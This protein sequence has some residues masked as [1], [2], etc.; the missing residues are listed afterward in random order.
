MVFKYLLKQINPKMIKPCPLYGRY[1]IDKFSFGR[2]YFITL[3]PNEY[4]Y[5][6]L[7]VDGA[8]KATA[9]IVVDFELTDH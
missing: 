4:R 3:E 6:F 9:Q 2:Q 7:M 8:T 5:H 1:D